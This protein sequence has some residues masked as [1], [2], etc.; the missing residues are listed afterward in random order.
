MKP[1]TL[2][3]LAT[4]FASAHP[5]ETSRAL[6]E[7]PAAEAAHFLE[8][9][10]SQLASSITQQLTAL[11]FAACL[12]CM[13]VD[14][15]ASVLTEMPFEKV[16]SALRRVSTKERK[17]LVDALPRDRRRRLQALLKYPQETA[18]ALMEPLVLTVG[19]RLTVGQVRKSLVRH[20]AHLRYYVYVVDE[21][22]GLLGVVDL[23]RLMNVDRG[24]L[25]EDLM[26][27]DPERISA[28]AGRRAM[29]LHP[30]WDR[31]HTLPVVDER[32]VLLGILRHQRVRQ[33]E[34]GE[35]GRVEGGSA[36]AALA[37]LFWSGA[38]RVTGEL[39]G[40]AARRSL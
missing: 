26:V 21:Q 28:R 25:I 33:L 15:A 6:A 7:L 40:L 37:D 39:M 11:E 17:A 36:R 23:R 38:Q 13:S 18:G 20:S 12:H 22:E 19:P 14:R 5:Q 31:V 32:N 30:A 24:M 34:R 9:C 4:E 3:F 1:T 16:A 29:M 10:S 35:R 8:T 2:E 27:R